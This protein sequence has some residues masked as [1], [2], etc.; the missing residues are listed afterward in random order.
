MG[1]LEARSRPLALGA[2]RFGALVFYDVGHAA[3]SHQ[4][5]AA[6]TRTWA[7]ACA[8]SSRS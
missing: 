2:L 5:P 4:R 8:C 6:R 7:S 1:H 3:A